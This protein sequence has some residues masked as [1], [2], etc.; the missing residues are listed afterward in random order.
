MTRSEFISAKRRFQREISWLGIAW[1]GLWAAVFM[2]I[3]F[4]FRF[5]FHDHGVVFYS[6]L[7]V[8]VVGFLVPFF[9]MSRFLH[10][11]HRMICPACGNWLVATRAEETGRCSQCQAEVFSHG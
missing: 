1:T 3:G 10:R 9:F 11:R 2:G 8:G 6:F 4:G 5:W 7:V